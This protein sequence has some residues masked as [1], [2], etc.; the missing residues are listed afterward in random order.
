MKRVLISTVLVFVAFSQGVSAATTQDIY[1]AH[2]AVE[3]S[4]GVIAPWYHGQ[5]GQSD[6]RVR[7]AAETLKRYPW[8]SEDKKVTRYPHYVYSGA[9]RIAEDGTITIPMI[10]GWEN[11]DLGQRAAYVFRS[12][13]DYYQYTGDAAALA[14]IYYQAEALL[15][16]ALTGDDHPWPRFPISVPLRGKPYE[17]ADSD[18]F[19]QLDIVGEIGVGLVQA[20]QITGNERWMKAARH[21]G[22]LL[23]RKRHTVPGMNP[24]GRYANPQKAA[25]E[26]RATGGVAFILDFFD[27]LIRTGYTG[28][29]DCIVH[30]RDDAIAYM[31]EVLL[32][33]WEMHDTWGRNYWDWPCYVQVGNVTEFAARY[34]MDHPEIFPKW[35]TD[36]RNIT[37]LFMQRACSSMN[38]RGDVFSGAWAYPESSGCC[39]R[40]LWYAPL[41]LVNVFAQYGE[42]ADS[43]WAEEIARRKLILATYDF[44]ETGVVEDNIDGGPIVAGSWFKIAHPMALKHV[45][46]AMAWQPNYFGAVRENHIMRSSSVVRDVTY[47]DGEIRY[48]TADAP[49]NTIDVLRLAF[50]PKEI[51]ADGQALTVR[52]D[53][54]ENGYLVQGLACGDYLVTVRH[55]DYTNVVIRGDDPQ[56]TISADDLQY[57]GQWEKHKVG[58]STTEKNAAMTCEFTGN[59]VRLIGGFGPDGGK[60]DIYLDGEKQLVGIDYW[61]P[62]A[63]DGQVLYYKN[64]LSNEKHV[65]KV[66]ACGEGNPHSDGHR[67]SIHSVQYSAAEGEVDFGEGS[68]PRDAQRFI[69]GYTSRDDYVDSQGHHWR[70]G[71][72]LVIRSG[73]LVDTVAASWYTQRRQIEILDTPDPELYR[74]GIH[75][76]EFRAEFTVAPGTYHARL[77]FSETRNIEPHLRGINIS[78][79]GEQ[80]VNN[81]DIAATAA[82]LS[83]EARL[84]QSALPSPIY[85]G[86]RQAVDLVFNNIQPRNGMIT[87][88][89]Q[90][91]AGAEA[92]V[93][94]IE[95]GPGDGGEGAKPVQARMPAGAGKAEEDDKNLLSNGGFEKGFDGQVGS[96]GRN[97][98]SRSWHYVFASARRCYIFPESAYNIHPELGEPMFHSGKE[99]IRTHTDG[100]GHT[101]LLQELKVE[102]ETGYKASAWCQTVDL[103]G[104]GFGVAASDAAKLIVQE[105][106]TNGQTATVHSSKPIVAAGDFQ[107]VALEFK[108]TPKTEKVRFIL[109]T[110]ISGSYHHGHVT[111]DACRLEPIP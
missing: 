9:W 48:V 41:E 103:D 12:W 26:D 27:A 111:W 42:L 85:K 93:Q 88:R 20:A 15:D 79:N 6:F 7:V 3:D 30:A 17:Q 38:S 54:Q 55:D 90:G 2:P 75:G 23:A 63:R 73:N 32:P 65:L 14:H 94:A 74:Y 97:G 107:E 40:S 19:I 10:N 22:D 91:E 37:T 78:I 96:L 64:G 35:R 76:K 105:V 108:T 11:G 69:F 86:L 59:Q 100:N 70:P 102:P 92:I 109:D 80:K 72:E 39:G 28:K 67:V 106:D 87:I 36:V 43:D 68:G 46:H 60:A 77:K 83:S 62:N 53:W 47:G 33:Q 82:G 98:A 49:N 104:K 34:M 66:V 24:W 4:H 81:M 56:E 13:V 71:T 31:K 21:W 89:L 8:T 29:N 5:N 101:I 16:Y 1:Y 61:N 58:R 44:H 45:L 52:E 57:T 110:Q 84:T 50:S 95:V 51:I 18:G 99:A 25:W